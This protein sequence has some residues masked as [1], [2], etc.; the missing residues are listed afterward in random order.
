M[1]ISNVHLSSNK[2]II[3]KLIILILVP[4]LKLAL[5]RIP[6]YPDVNNLTVYF[7]TQCVANASA[8]ADVSGKQHL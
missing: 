8:S 2:L 7:F 1:I 5:P 4:V 3:K 6:I